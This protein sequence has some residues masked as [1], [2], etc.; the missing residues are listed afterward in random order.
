MGEVD[1]DSAAE[2]CFGSLVFEPP[3]F[4]LAFEAALDA[5]RSKNS[6]DGQVP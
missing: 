6:N 5:V 2:A 1:E 3:V 4:Q